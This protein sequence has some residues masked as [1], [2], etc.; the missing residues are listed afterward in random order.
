MRL[1]RRSRASLPPAAT[2][3]TAAAAT[4]SSASGRLSTSFLAILPRS[5]ERRIYNGTAPLARD[6]GSGAS[7]WSG[8]AGPARR[9]PAHSW[10]MLMSPPA[11]P[12]WSRC[13]N[14]PTRKIHGLGSFAASEGAL[15]RG[16]KR[17]DLVEPGDFKGGAYRAG[18]AHDAEPSVPRAQAMPGVQ[19]DG[20]TRGVHEP[21]PG[22][23]DDDVTL[24]F[25]DKTVEPRSDIGSGE[26]VEIA[27]HRNQARVAEYSLL[28]VE[29]A[30]SRHQRPLRLPRYC[31]QSAAGPRARVRPHSHLY[32]PR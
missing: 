25:V 8:S 29:V 9:L 12:A 4:A 31:G 11:T 30:S 27:R 16:V 18:R 5:P 13:M 21:D 22:E 1:V 3:A 23:V 6:R 15:A 7:G 20:E 19:K 24:F 26:E 14:R 32:A 10:G 28:D 2:P 17:E